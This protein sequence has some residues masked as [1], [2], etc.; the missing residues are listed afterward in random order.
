MLNNKR[1]C[2]IHEIIYNKFLFLNLL[3]IFL[4]RQNGGTGIFI[5]SY[6]TRLGDG[7]G[8]CVKMGRQV[9]PYIHTYPLIRKNIISNG[10]E[11]VINILKSSQF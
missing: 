10:L 1:K 7:I 6:L 2:V 5:L 4:T 11:K 9:F 3:N 8:F